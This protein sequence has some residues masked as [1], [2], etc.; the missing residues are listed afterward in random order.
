MIFQEERVELSTSTGP[1]QTRVYR[2][3]APGRYPGLVLF[4]EIFQV[5]EP[6]QRTAAMLAGHGFVVAAPDIYH[7]LEPAG[8][9]LAYD[10]E[11][12]QRGNAHKVARP[13]TSYDDDARAV[14][15]YLG[16]SPHCT[17]KLG[18]IGICIG[19]HL[20][21]RCAMNPE[22]LAAVTFYATDIHKGSLGKGGDDSLAR[23]GD[24][25]GEICMF[26]GRQD[27]HVPTEGRRTIYDALVD[28]GVNFT[29]HEF[30]GQHAFIRDLGHRYDPALAYT[31]YGI[32]L[33]LFKRKLNEGD[34]PA[35]DAGERESRH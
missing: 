33:E 5:T 11:G 13:V 9:E 18:C 26:W 25:R 19:G 6:I 24:I 34:L 31:C 7:E 21:F 23:A 8:T 1:M 15:E 17:G 3:V 27:P 20:S 4:S 12:A 28:A 35:A 22:I 2:P 30:N 10:D 32:T 16:E 14:I 29:W